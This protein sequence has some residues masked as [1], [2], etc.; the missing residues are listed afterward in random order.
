LF[1]SLNFTK[2]AAATLVINK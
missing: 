2:T 1:A